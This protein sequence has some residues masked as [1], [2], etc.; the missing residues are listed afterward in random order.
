MST[1]YIPPATRQL[2]T[3]R[4]RHRCEYCQTQA[5][6][7]GMPLEIEHIVPE[8]AGGS[9]EESNL[10]LACSSCNRYKGIRMNGVDT[11]TNETVALFHPRQHKWEDH[12]AWAQDSL[13]LTGLTPTGRATIAVLQ[14][15]NPFVVRSRRVWI[16]SGWHP[17]QD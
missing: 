14:I 9:S 4:A 13:Y 8:V 12:F 10:G 5:L 17:P 1:T 2:V 15:N 3:E 16:L 11:E 6:I 7:L